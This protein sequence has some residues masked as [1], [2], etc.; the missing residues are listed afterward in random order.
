VVVDESGTAEEIGTETHT[1]CRETNPVNESHLGFKL[2]S[3]LR[4]AIKI[5][6]GFDQAMLVDDSTLLIRP[7]IDSWAAEQLATYNA[8]LLGVASE[9]TYSGWF[10]RCTAQLDQW[11]LPYI[12]HDSGDRPIAEGL[13]FMSRDFC[14]ELFARQ[15]LPPAD[16]NTWPLTVGP[17]LSWTA[18]LLDYPQISWGQQDRPEP[19]IYL[20]TAGTRRLPPPAILSEKFMAFHSIRRV[21]GFSETDI[22]KWAKE[23]R[24]G[25]NDVF[26]A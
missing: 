4:S 20:E 8:G 21:R 12:R 3:A 19:P 10:A 7:G 16:W 5:G 6:V 2:L 11:Q 14:E 25:S 17:Y 26:V 13:C 23:L 24:K 15:L 1:V 18:Q 22:R 9:N